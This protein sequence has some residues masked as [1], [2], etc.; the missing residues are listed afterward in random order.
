MDATD[1]PLVSIV[2][3]LYNKE[4]FVRETLCSAIA[5]MYAPIEV[6]VVDDGSTDDSLAVARDALRATNARVVTV[7]NGGVSSARS[8]GYRHVAPNAKYVLFLDA[9]DVLVPEAISRLVQHL[10]RY[11]TAVA[12]YGSVTFVDEMGA[13]LSEAPDQDRWVRTATG[14][15]R[16]GPNEHVTPLDAIWSRFW[17]L[18][19]TL[20]IRREAFDQVAGWDSQLC[21]P[22]R[23]FHAEDK[24]MAIQ[25]A[26]V[27]ELHHIGDRLVAYRVLPSAHKEA[28]YEGLDALDAKWSSDTLSDAHRRQVRH[29]LWFDARV[30]LLDAASSLVPYSRHDGPVVDHLMNLVRSS[31]KFVTTGWRIRTARFGSH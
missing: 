31:A 11:A 10:E 17:A 29:A 4:T 14:R 1:E 9:D 12:C 26:L 5:Q 20:L 21:R 8:I 18:P 28:V 6:V 15:R 7:A 16:L 23:P 25:L 30:R 22:A 3:S 24:D 2:V 27:G 13:S 19:S